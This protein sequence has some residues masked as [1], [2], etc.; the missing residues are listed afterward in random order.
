M[1]F[2]FTPGCR[3][4]L[5]DLQDWYDTQL[6]G[7]GARFATGFDNTLRRVLANP[8]LYGRVSRA[9]RNREVRVAPVHPFLAL[10]TYELTATEVVILSVTHAR[11]VHQPW[12]RRLP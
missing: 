2:R 5:F 8:R 3:L 12:R 4:D 6:P 11:S 1:N 10:M 9:P 7:L